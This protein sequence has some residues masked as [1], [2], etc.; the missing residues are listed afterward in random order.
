MIKRNIQ[1]RSCESKVLLT[2]FQLNAAGATALTDSTANRLTAHGDEPQDR[3]GIPHAVRA[4][5]RVTHAGTPA[6]HAVRLLRR[7][8]AA[9]GHHRSLRS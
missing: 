3:A 8:G 1:R 2:L 5:G 6:G 9:P 7:P 4:G